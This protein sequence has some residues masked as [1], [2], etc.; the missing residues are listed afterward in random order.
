MRFKTPPFE[1]ASVLAGSSSNELPL[2]AAQLDRPHPAARGLL[3]FPLLTFVALW[4]MACWGLS[5]HWAS[6]PQYEYG[7]FVPALS[8]FAGYKR[9]QTRPTPGPPAHIGL[10]VAGIGCALLLPSWLFLQPNPDWPLFNWLFVAQ[11]VATIMGAIA[12]VGGWK[13]VEYFFFPVA[14]IFTA[15]PWPD[16]IESPLMQTLMRTAA[17]S[18]VVGLDLFGVTALQHGNLLEVAGG[19]VGVDE[20]C[21]GIRSLQGSLMAAI[22]LG[23]LFRFGFSRRLLLIGVSLGTAFLTNILRV[24]FLAW[25]AVASG[26]AGV[27][28]WH[29]PAG[30]TILLV[31]VVVIL[32]VALLLD[33]KAPPVPNLTDIRPAHPLPRW[34]APAIAAWVG[35]TVVGVEL[36][37]YDHVPPP[38]NSWTVKLPAESKSIRVAPTALAQLRYDEVTG[39]EWSEADGKRW[40]LYFFDWNF[41]P[42]FARVAAQMHRPDICLPATGR[43]LQADRGKM[44]F[45]I[46]GEPIPFHAYA[47]KQGNELLF[48]YH[49]VWQF[50]SHRGLQNGPL[51]AWKHVASVQSVLWRER[52][53][54]QQSAELA[55]W[56]CTN[57][58]EADAAFTRIL[59][60][61]IVR[62]EAGP[63]LTP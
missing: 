38:P 58:M 4:L 14:L 13:W 23:E 2:L 62:R 27:D 50:R 31:C 61:L 21:S 29:D 3:S 49:G 44:T 11:V 55:V 48:V 60:S 1:S 37:Y 36:W 7:W 34:F 20:A 57:A 16:Q 28:R 32:G 41:G 9:W 47:F 12:A 18:A 45:V 46:G 33:K 17:A 42:A 19:V 15:V 8:L 30:T 52:Y 63:S 25:S 40:M 10:W 5:G 56:G 22:F 59:P 43:E 54:G 24:G 51:S 53:I 26:V 6:N 39:A 35:F